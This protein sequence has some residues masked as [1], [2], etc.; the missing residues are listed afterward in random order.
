MKNCILFSGQDQSEIYLSTIHKKEIEV[1]GTVTD[2][3][4]SWRH[5][6]S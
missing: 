1:V 2:K 3:S 5:R 6:D 4:Q